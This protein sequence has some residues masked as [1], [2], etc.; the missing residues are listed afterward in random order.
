MHN[1]LELPAI[2]CGAWWLSG[3]F[4]VLRPEGRRFNPTLAATNSDLASLSHMISLHYYVTS[5]L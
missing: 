2:D 4:S 3:G 1:A 5:L